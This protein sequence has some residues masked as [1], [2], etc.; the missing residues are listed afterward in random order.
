LR[1]ER[2]VEATETLESAGVSDSR[3]GQACVGEKTLCKK[4]PV[5]LRK[6]ERRRADLAFQSA[7]QMSLADAEVTGELRD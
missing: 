1:A 6:L 3:Y 5:R 2:R 4:E 7:S